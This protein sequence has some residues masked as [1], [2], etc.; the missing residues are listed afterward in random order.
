MR[1]PSENE[2]I[3][4]T[5]RINELF[6]KDLSAA[7]T[8]EKRLELAE[9]L[10]TT[11]VDEKNDHAAQ[12]QALITARDLAV[13]A[14]DFHLACRAIVQLAK[15]FYVDKLA[16]EAA[17]AAELRGTP[18]PMTDRRLFCLQVES[19][20]Q[21]LSAQGRFEQIPGLDEIARSVA[22]STS[23]PTLGRQVRKYAE[24]HTS[25]KAAY[26]ALAGAREALAKDPANGPANTAMGKYECFEQD[27]WEHGLPLLAAGSD[28]DLKQAAQADPT[29]ATPDQ[30]CLVANAWW[31][32]AQTQ[33]DTEKQR[34]LN[35]IGPLYI[36]ALP[37]LSGF[38]KE[39][40]VKRLATIRSA[41]LG[42]PA[43]VNLLDLV[44][45]SR[46]TVAGQWTP[47]DALGSLTSASGDDSRITFL[48]HPPKEYEY[49]VVFTRADGNNALDL[50][51]LGGDGD[52]QF[53]FMI[54]GVDNT[55]AGFGLVQAQ[56]AR[57]NVTTIH[58]FSIDNQKRYTLMVRV[59]ADGVQA[60]LNDKPLGREYF[61]DF[62]DLGL[63]QGMDLNRP[64]VVGLMASN[65]KYIIHSAYIAE[66]SGHGHRVAADDPS[67]SPVVASAT[68]ASPD[69]NH[70][71]FV[72]TLHANGTVDSTMG[73][74]A[75]WFLRGND[76]VFRWGNQIDTCKLSADRKSFTGK[77]SH[78]DAVQGQITDGGV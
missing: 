2:L 30:K 72:V 53:R 65:S 46:D 63:Y 44:D 34:I 39:I 73:Q 76:L 7:R 31:E 71:P 47:S 1:I 28:S 69:N 16:Y 42:D 22:A 21:S 48:Y 27:D 58:N 3:A 17:A 37:G 33:G 55:T 19:I 29:N 9:A 60:F 10:I 18:I 45:L 36:K 56:S 66:I 74:T 40:A 78:G 61:S 62:R 68:Y 51:C 8:A 20:S 52:R 5:S 77:T 59:R 12:F 4:A 50:F 38:E 67:D 32:I 49:H 14:Q 25:A 64:D 6:G 24:E 35:H 11:A 13:K 54:G 15:R 26:I 41:M 70:R 57:S 75:V 43:A 23:D